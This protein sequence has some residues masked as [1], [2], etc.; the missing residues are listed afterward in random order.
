MDLE[1]QADD[2]DR[3]PLASSVLPRHRHVILIVRRPSARGRSAEG[4]P[5]DRRTGSLVGLEGLRTLSFGAQA[6]LPGL[7]H[8]LRVGQGKRMCHVPAYCYLD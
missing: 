8:L 2:R 7:G 3:E 4:P 6:E 5:E 1:A